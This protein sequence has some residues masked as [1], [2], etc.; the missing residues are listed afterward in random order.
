[1]PRP[2]DVAALSA[3]LVA[4][5]TS[6][7]FIR[8]TEATPTVI[9]FWRLL[10]AG[11]VFLA[12]ELAFGGR[13]KIDRRELVIALVA[14]AFLSLHFY[15][16]VGSLFMTS[17]NSSVVLLATQPLFAL[18]IQFF[19]LRLPVAGRNLLS[20]AAGVAGAALIAR[21]DFHLSADAGMGDLF[22]IASA[23]M[24]ACYLIVGS[25]RR[26]PLLTYLVVVYTASGLMLLATALLLGDPLLP[27][28][29]IDWLWLALLALLPTLVGHTALNRAMKQFPPYMVNLSIL[30][31][32]ILTAVFAWYVFGE[33]V[34]RHLAL[35]GALIALA[36]V[37]EIAP[38]RRS[39]AG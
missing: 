29:G 19:V 4:I 20:L 13:L 16:W 18:L 17:I 8:L 3:G 10:M 5:A 23:L 6:A 2:R 36:L 12:A 28:R 33:V 27:R 9:S 25:Y 22:S 7:I 14:A 34:T 1:M 31:E 37:I 15:L 21:A 38:W 11:G 24:A 26:G 30:S 39:V 32:P 35:G